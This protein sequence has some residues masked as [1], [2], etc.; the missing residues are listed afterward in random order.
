MIIIISTYI[1]DEYDSAADIILQ[2]NSVF[3]R[4]FLRWDAFY[5]LHLAEEGYVY[6]QEHAFLPLFPLLVRGFGNTLYLLSLGH[7]LS[8]RIT[9]LLSGVLLSNFFFACATIAF[10]NLSNVL[11]HNKKFA[12]ISSIIYILTPSCI[13]MSSLYAESLF[14]FLSFLG[15]RWVVEKHYWKAA[16]TWSLASMTRSNGIVYVG[17][18]IFQLLLK[19]IH[20]LEVKTF[21]QN[22]LNCIVLSL[23]TIFGFLSFERFGYL[24]YCTD[25]ISIRPWCQSP[26]PLLYTFVQK[27]YWQ[28]QNNFSEFESF[29]LEINSIK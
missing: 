21:V 28:V 26:I 22:L 13:F 27:Y 8:Y 10:F 12:M 19:N 15:M 17:F 14:A 24:R 5:F 11:F 25:P 9:L 1:L 20:G 7:F 29:Q 4:G 23:I 16:F 3:I 2:G 18:F 6:E